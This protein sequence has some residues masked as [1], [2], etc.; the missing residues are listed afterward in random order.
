MLYGVE[1]M[2]L[3][4]A[5]VRS[6]ENCINRAMY[7]IFGSCDRSSL[8][9]IRICAKIDNMTDLIQKKCDKFVDQLIGDGLFNNL[10]FISSWMYFVICKF[11][12]VAYLCVFS[13][14][15]LLTVSSYLLHLFAR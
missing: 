3:S 5:N 2:S 8:E 1:A 14:F 4:F 13:T 6:L 12:Y 11:D 15:V 7:K 9:Y 10:L